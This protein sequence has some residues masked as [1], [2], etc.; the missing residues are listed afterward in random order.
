MITR[1]QGLGKAWAREF[2]REARVARRTQAHVID[3]QIQTESVDGEPTGRF[4][5]RWRCSC[6]LTGKRWQDSL[7]GGAGAAAK[8][9]RVGGARHVTAMERGK[10]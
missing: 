2:A 1:R 8:R 6:A 10:R 9:A 3:L 7:D 4:R 5:Y